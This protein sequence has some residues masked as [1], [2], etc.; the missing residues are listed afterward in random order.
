M[1]ILSAERIAFDVKVPVVIIS[2]LAQQALLQP[3]RHAKPD[4]MSSFW[5][6]MRCHAARRPFRLD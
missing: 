2:V 6:V 5:N 3:C 4:R 1:S